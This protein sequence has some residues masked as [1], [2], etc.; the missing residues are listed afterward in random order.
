MSHDE[1]TSSAPRPG[2]AA[3]APRAAD[4]RSAAQPGNA[5]A[6]KR[7]AGARSAAQPGN[8]A[9]ALG[10]LAID[11]G[12]PLGS[13]YLLHAALGASVWLSLALSSL[14]PAARSAWGLTAGRRINVLALLMLS[15]NLA[16]IVVSFL[17][18]DPRAMIAK[19]SVVSSVIAF[20]ILGS[21]AAR[22]P[23]MSTALK[24]FMTRG[25]PDRTAAWDRLSA[26][27]A[28]FR[29][30]EY[31]YSLTWGLAL[32]ADC[33]ARLA[34]AFLLPVT[35]MVWL[36]TVFILG[37]I[38]V[39]VVAGCVCWVPI[40]T[41][42]SA[43]AQAAA[44]AAPVRPLPGG[45]PHH[46][47]GRG[48]GH[49]GHDLDDEHRVRQ[50]RDVRELEA[51]DADRVSQDETHDSAGHQQQAGHDRQQV[52][53]DQQGDRQQDG[54]DH[55][56]EE[57]LVEGFHVPV[58]DVPQV[59]VDEAGGDQEACIADEEHPEPGRALPPLTGG[60]PFAGR[61]HGSVTSFVA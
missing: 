18:G 54:R 30:I 3:P 50:V 14:G 34:G 9:A 61:R 60:M 28:R 37:A 24:P 16:G 56:Q 23:L 48:Q 46:P 2:D 10:P 22:R 42:I 35:T 41:M 40:E 25:A 27:S 6:G 26:G 4:A 29:R 51:E 19:D 12:I 57:E 59:Q 31:L 32:L 17:T 38:S 1:R 55:L 21:V 13:Y 7:A 8:V 49:D 52:P 43:A 47:A 58:G 33:I 45:A 53:G 5:A 44:V 39:G 20:A 15:V 11:V 36:S